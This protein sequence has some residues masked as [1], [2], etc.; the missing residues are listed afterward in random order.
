MS[1]Q[2]IWKKLGYSCLS[3]GGGGPAKIKIR[4]HIVPKRSTQSE[5][6]WVKVE[7]RPTLNKQWSTH[8]DTHKRCR[9]PDTSLPSLST[10]SSFCN[11]T[12][13]T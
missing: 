4:F 8:L 6:R 7:V 3:R 13:V 5:C 10:D 9:L 1:V 2:G 12:R 11:V